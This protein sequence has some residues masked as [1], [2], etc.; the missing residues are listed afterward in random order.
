MKQLPPE[1]W[2]MILTYKTFYEILDISSRKSFT[3]VRVCVTDP[4]SELD[5]WKC[6]GFNVFD[7]DFRKDLYCRIYETKRIRWRICRLDFIG[8]R[9][10][11]REQGMLGHFVHSFK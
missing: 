1:L 8:K 6:Y 10:R 5:C 3:L 2:S 11:R 7:E 4:R 9:R